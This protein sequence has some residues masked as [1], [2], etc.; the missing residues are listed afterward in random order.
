MLLSG[1]VG[2]ANPT[3]SCRRV[4]GEIGRVLVISVEPGIKV[5]KGGEEESRE[6]GRGE[7][8]GEDEGGE[9]TRA[10]IRVEEII[11]V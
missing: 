3:G 10:G 1:G 9:I 4:G 7:E 11:P 2:A 8:G 5:R 6:R